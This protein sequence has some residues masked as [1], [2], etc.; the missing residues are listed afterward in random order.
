L[1]WG[2][3]ATAQAKRGDVQAAL[4]TANSIQVSYYRGQ[5]VSAMVAALT[6]TNEF[7]EARRLADS[8]PSDYWRLNAFVLLAKAQI[9][10]GQRD[11]AERLMETVQR[12]ADRVKDDEKLPVRGLKR[13]LLYQLAQAQ[14]QAGDGQAACEWI[15]RQSSSDIR[16]LAYVGLAEGLLATE[17][18]KGGK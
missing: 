16:A 11:A 12:E 13:A 2:N 5:A 8:I 4:R 3:I 9:R 1:A 17:P 14:S 18:K 15:V 10:A 7:A 6:Q